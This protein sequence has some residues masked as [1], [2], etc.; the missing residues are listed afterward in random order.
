MSALERA[1]APAARSPHGASNSPTRTGLTLGERLKVL[2]FLRVVVVTLLSVVALVAELQDERPFVA[3]SADRFFYFTNSIVFIISLGYTLL[4]R[5]TQR[6][7]VHRIHARVQIA[8][9]M[10]YVT[11]LVL[12]TRMTDSVFVFLFP[13]VIVAGAILLYR[14]GAAVTVGMAA[15]LFLLVGFAQLELHGFQGF[16]NQLGA[17]PH[18][19]VRLDEM[20]GLSGRA[21]VVHNLSVNVLAFCLI[22]LLSSYLTEQIRRTRVSL[23]ENRL[24]LEALQVLHED[25]VSSLPVALLTTD[26][27]HRVTFVNPQGILLAGLDESEMLGRRVTSFFPVLRTILDNEDKLKKPHSE[28]TVLVLHGRQVHLRWTISPLRTTDG[29]RTGQVLVVQD[30]TRVVKMEAETKRRDRLATV[31]KFAAGMAHEIR[32]PLASISGSIQLLR[33]TAALDDQD[34]RLM[35]IVLREADSLNERVREFLAYA[36]PKSLERRLF[37][38]VDL[39]VETVDVFR[40]DPQAEGR[41][42]AMQDPWPEDPTAEADRERIKQVLWNLLCN[43]AEATEIGDRIEVGI[44]NLDHEGQAFLSLS[45]RDSGAGILPGDMKRVTEPFFTTKE[46]GTGLGLATV[47]R[48]AEEH[49]GWLKVD[50]EAGDGANFSVLIPKRA[51]REETPDLEALDGGLRTPSGAHLP[52]IWSR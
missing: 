12:I 48:I 17:P 26:R 41:E 20:G 9:D 42:L 3:G 14:R 30:V 5:L 27:D 19:L 33:D 16:L 7:S 25:V 21:G 52:A 28:T 43:A 10:A 40:N 39:V 1:S 6:Q 47:Q 23:R 37:S 22:G 44:E 13:V 18:V 29:D 46:G 32:N 36:R 15:V 38:L 8:V 50:S 2:I 4:L 11:L 31:G 34:R 24:N 51:V 45:V 49:G 35:D